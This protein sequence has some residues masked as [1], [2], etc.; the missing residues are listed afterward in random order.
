MTEKRNV[1]ILKTRVK[2][3]LPWLWFFACLAAL[4][5]FMQWRLEYV[6]DSDISSELVLANLLAGEKAIL[7]ANWYYSTE[8]HVWFSQLIF[9]P[10]FAVFSNWHT[11]RMAGSF[12]LYAL[13]LLSYYYLCRRLRLKR[14]YLWT[15][16]V[17]LLPVSTVYFQFAIYATAYTFYVANAFLILAMMLH[18]PR[19]ENRTGRAA[20][21]CGVGALSL[22]TGMNGPRYL[23]V[24]YAPLCLAA[25]ALLLRRGKALLKNGKPRLKGEARFAFL[26]VAVFASLCAAAGYLL[27][28]EILAR[29]YSFFQYDSIRLDTPTFARLEALVNGWL[30]VFGTT[31]R[32]RFFPCICCKTCFASG[33]WR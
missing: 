7:S 33:S 27:N 18:L 23:M 4:F 24:F 9:A 6:L 11:V 32:A 29:A 28:R 8:L 5:A 21:A 13:V 10:L 3:T 19:C 2:R 25:L 1:P 30:I 17:L 12:I 22:L 31:A 15:A 20:L 16:P 26:T 14:L